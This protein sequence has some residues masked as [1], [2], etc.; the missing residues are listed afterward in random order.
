MVLALTYDTSACGPHLIN[1][2]S[3]SH[4]AAARFGLP[5]NV[6]TAGGRAFAT[7]AGA[8]ISQTDQVVLRY[9]P[10]CSSVTY[11][12]GGGIRWS[13]KAN[14]GIRAAAG[15]S[16]ANAAGD[17]KISTASSSATGTP[18]ACRPAVDSR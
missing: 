15:L 14:R 16:S 1:R 13:A 10:A 6:G 17:L 9:L 8:L 4:S 2:Q 18:R 3:V 11:L 12:F 7:S 5:S